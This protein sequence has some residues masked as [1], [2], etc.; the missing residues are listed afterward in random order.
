[1][2]TLIDSISL[3]GHTV[4]TLLV[5]AE[6]KYQGTKN[7][8]EGIVIRDLESSRSKTLDGALLS[9]KVINNKYLLKEE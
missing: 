8:R 9:F 5:M 2:H 7:E 3:E 6:G 4:D 1:M